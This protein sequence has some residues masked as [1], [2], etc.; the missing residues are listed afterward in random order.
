MKRTIILASAA[1][2]AVS[3]SQENPAA[4]RPAATTPQPLRVHALPGQAPVSAAPSHMDAAFDQQ[5]AAYA[6]QGA[7][8]VTPAVSATLPA[9]LPTAGY[10]DTTGGTNAALISNPGLNG[11]PAP[12]S[13]MVQPMITTPAMQALPTPTVSQQ[14]ISV[15]TAA[16]SLMP[17]ATAAPAAP[18]MGG[19]INYKMQITNMTPGRVFV[20]AQDAA[21][22]IYPCGFMD[23]KDAQT[24]SY[25][26][27][28][29]NAAPIQGPITVVVRDPDKE[30]SPEIR[31]YKVNPPT[32]N[33]AGKTVSISIMPGGMY[34]AS[35]DGHIYY[36]SLP[37]VPVPEPNKP[38][39]PAPESVPA[40]Q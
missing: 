38:A 36:Q 1:L 2:L 21:G 3:C 19:S 29:E 7:T 22:T 12:Q 9:T 25:T 15:P 30:G 33:Y 17:D 5:V 39:E 40:G 37:E 34:L 16:P 31:R 20:E 32:T 8:S 6:N 14:D 10:T 13:A 35:V 18:A 23:G 26:T 27:P 4:I 28:M 24:R 11:M